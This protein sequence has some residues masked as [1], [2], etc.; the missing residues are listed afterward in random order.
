MTTPEEETKKYRKSLFEI[1]HFKA[2]EYK[3]RIWNDEKTKKIP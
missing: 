1:T 3:P 2:H